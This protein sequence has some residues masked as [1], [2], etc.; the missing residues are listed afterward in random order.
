MKDRGESREHGLALLLHRGKITADAAKRGSSRRTAKAARN[1]LLHFRH[2]KVSL[3]LIVGKRNAQ[4]VEQGQHLLSTTQQGIEQIL[5]GT[6][7][8]PTFL[9]FRRRGDRRRL[10]RI[11]CQFLPLPL[12][13][14][15]DA[16]S[17]ASGRGYN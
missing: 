15:R 7:F 6:L 1:L 12:D 4:V 17:D 3:S 11:T 14:E 13:H 16:N 9:F 2:P 5:G 10:S 8:A